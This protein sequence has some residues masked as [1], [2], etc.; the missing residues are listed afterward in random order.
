MQSSGWKTSHQEVR[1]LKRSVI[2]MGFPKQHELGI[3]PE[4]EYFML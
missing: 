2:I 3:I 1:K 4:P